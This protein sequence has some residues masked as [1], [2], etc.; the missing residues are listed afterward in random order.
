[1]G[2]CVCLAVYTPF[3]GQDSNETNAI[4]VGKI[5]N[6]KLWSKLIL[7]NI[8]YKISGESRIRFS[9]YFHWRV[10]DEDHRPG[11]HPTPE[12]IPEECLEHS[13]LYYCDD[14]VG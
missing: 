13:R 1:M 8:F 2:N 7:I 10:H 14:R 9:V 11:F 6:I 12:C 4:L 5:S 3:P